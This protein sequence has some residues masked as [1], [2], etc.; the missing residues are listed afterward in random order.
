MEAD[1]LAAERPTASDRPQLRAN[2]E[3]QAPYTVYASGHPP[4]E[5]RQSDKNAEKQEQRQRNGKE[6]ERRYRDVYEP[7]WS[8]CGNERSPDTHDEHGDGHA[9]PEPA[10]LPVQ[11]YAPG[12]D[13]GDLDD[14]ECEPNCV[15]ETVDDE[16]EFRCRMQGCPAGKPMAQKEGPGE[17]EEDCNSNEGGEAEIEDMFES[18]CPSADWRREIVCRGI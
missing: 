8:P 10:H 4:L 7:C 1:W 14:E 12:S 18:P 6:L 2:L 3:R 9:T 5:D 13:E 11:A 15:D 17:A 16:E